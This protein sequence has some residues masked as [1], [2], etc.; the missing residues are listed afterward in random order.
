MAS[1][2]CR[3]I[4][5]VSINPNSQWLCFR[6]LFQFG[7]LHLA[8]SCHI[9]V[10][11][12]THN[13]PKSTY[14]G[15]TMFFSW[16]GTPKWQPNDHVG[17]DVPVSSI[18]LGQRQI[19]PAPLSAWDATEAQWQSM[20]IL[21]TAQSHNHW[22]RQLGAP[23]WILLPSRWETWNQVLVEK[24][25]WKWGQGT[26]VWYFPTSCPSTNPVLDASVDFLK[27]LCFKNYCYI[28]FLVQYYV[29]F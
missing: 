9:A 22:R 11:V 20:A 2:K 25:W 6:F 14:D 5:L 16:K 19:A 18:D 1:R 27:S 17:P 10:I 15:H 7:Q 24:L 3:K 8:S 26:G 23:N 29:C 21:W 28:L 12:I 13:L 4:W